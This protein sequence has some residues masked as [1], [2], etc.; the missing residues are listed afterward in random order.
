MK[1]Y[2]L[3]LLKG[4]G[5]GLYANGHRESTVIVQ[6][7]RSVDSLSPQL[8]KYFG[9]REITKAQLRRS[10]YVILTQVNAQYNT[11]FRHIVID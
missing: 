4:I 11:A 1:T 3:G 2:H 5:R 6:A 10:R 9:E 7:R 8:W